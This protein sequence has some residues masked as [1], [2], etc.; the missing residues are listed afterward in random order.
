MCACARVYYCVRAYYC[1]IE[2]TFGGEDRRTFPNIDFD[3]LVTLSSKILQN[4]SEIVLILQNLPKEIFHKSLVLI[5]YLRYK[6]VLISI[7]SHLDI[8][9]RDTTV[10]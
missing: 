4:P 3:C 9:E 7:N 10:D 1:G 5:P 8:E 6:G 2:E